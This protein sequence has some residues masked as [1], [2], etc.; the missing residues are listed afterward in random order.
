MIWNKT[1]PIP[2]FVENNNLVGIH[3]DWRT[4]TPVVFYMEENDPCK[5]M[6]FEMANDLVRYMELGEINWATP[7]CTR[8]AV[9][10]YDNDGVQI[11]SQPGQE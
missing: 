11:V 2:D 3:I 1:Q 9:Y 4:N 8:L 7:H 6:D 5:R 10:T